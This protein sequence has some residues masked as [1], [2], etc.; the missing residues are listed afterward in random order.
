[1]KNDEKRKASAV[2]KLG[3]LS[4]KHAFC[5]GC[6]QPGIEPEEM[7]VLQINLDKQA[8][9]LDERTSTLK[10]YETKSFG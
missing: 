10:D 6:H 9:H 1:M 3:E 2:E 5:L 8:K 4:P 7:P